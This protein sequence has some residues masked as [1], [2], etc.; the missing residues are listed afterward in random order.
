MKQLIET[1]DFELDPFFNL[2][3]DSLCIA[4][5]KGYFKKVNPAFTKLLGYTEEELYAKPIFDF[6]YEEDI[7][8]TIKH[9]ENLVQNMPLL[10]FENRYVCK[11]GKLVWMH[12]TAFT[13]EDRE[14]IYA[15]GK[16]VTHK[17]DLENERISHVT[18][19]ARINDRLMELN[20][21]TSHDL[22]SPVNNLVFLVEMLDSSKIKDE[23]ALTVL[24][25]IKRSANGLKTSLKTYVEAVAVAEESFLERELVPVC[26]DEVFQRVKKSIDTLA[27]N[28]KVEFVIDFSEA[29]WVLF[30]RSFMESILMN[31]ISNSIQ[32]ARP[33]VIPVISIKTEIED[34]TKKLTYSDNGLGVDMEK[35]GS[36]FFDLNKNRH[37]SRDSKGLG[38]YLVNKH[39]T[40]LGGSITVDSKE[41]QGSTFTILFGNLI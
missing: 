5:F 22:K 20:H 23:T 3:I 4:D 13:S 26:F 14:F 29:E 10:N 41:N 17:K 37:N 24:E 16:D 18:D 36:H 30:E 40:S 38:L 7:E 19:L 34:G 25:H 32:Y 35:E 9:G 1:L 15:I 27:C 39:V 11:D 8:A 12:W 33:G 2:S 21:I 28:A 31:L 6:I